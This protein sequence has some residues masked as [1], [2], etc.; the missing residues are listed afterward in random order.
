[1]R[2]SGARD[3][4]QV[5]T[6]AERIPGLFAQTNSASCARNGI[7]QP[8]AAAHVKYILIGHYSVPYSDDWWN[9]NTRT[10]SNENPKRK[11]HKNPWHFPCRFILRQGRAD[12]EAEIR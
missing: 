5:S 9:K 6:R 2:S 7:G 8:T 10:P 12:S 4:A 1:M 3:A 11:F